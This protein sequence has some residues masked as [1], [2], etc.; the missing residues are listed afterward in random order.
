MGFVVGRG[1]MGN[2]DLVVALG[3]ILLLGWVLKGVVDLR[4]GLRP[5]FVGSD[6]GGGGGWW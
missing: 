5:R 6:G 3:S 4:E 1:S 2:L